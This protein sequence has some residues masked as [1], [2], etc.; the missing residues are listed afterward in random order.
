MSGKIES[1][2]FRGT[3]TALVTP[4]RDGKVDERALESLV[5]RQIEAG[6]DGVVPCGSTGESATLS[7]DEHDRVIELV[8]KTVAGHCKIIAGTGSN[9]TAEAV[10]LTQTAADAGAD[11]ALIVAP[12]YN[13]PT[14]EGLFQHY[15]AI[16]KSVDLPIVLYNVPSR[17]AIDISNET[18]S[19]ICGEHD[20][21]AAI[22]D[23]SGG[24]TRVAELVDRFGVDVLC[25]DDSLTLSMMAHGAVGVISVIS[26]LVP[27]WMKELV[28]SATAGDFERCRTFHQ[29][30][31][32]LADEI[33]VLGP[34]PVPVKTA[35]ALTG[36][37]AE[38]LRLP[39]CKLAP[40]DR[41]RVADA[42]RRYELL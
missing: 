2:F 35:M 24:V 14:Q 10:R 9:C 16:A 22:K 6:V 33:G 34:N 29:K 31:C 27:E 37:I 5:E 23:A 11:G 7:H 42:L 8:I 4:F 3:Y 1:G 40:D 19:R 17:C 36:L 13:R 15:S 26:N 21:I 25:G 38:E 20:N 28:D 32:G 12:Y 30:A 41:N 39:L 18:V